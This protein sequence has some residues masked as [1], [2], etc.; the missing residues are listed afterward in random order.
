MATNETTTQAGHYVQANGLQIYYEEAGRGTPL[1][2]IH[3]GNVN[4]NMW[5]A[6]IPLF[7]QHFRDC[8]G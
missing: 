2:L 4:L 5:T 3:G 6:H 8:A 1:L 7:A